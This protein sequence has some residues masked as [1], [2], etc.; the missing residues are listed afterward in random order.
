LLLVEHE[1]GL[2]VAECV[3]MRLMNQTASR[4]TGT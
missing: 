1:K 2:R 3:R 4:D